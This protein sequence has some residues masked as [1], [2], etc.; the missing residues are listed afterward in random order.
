MGP[1][2]RSC[3]RQ[4]KAGSASDVNL[5]TIQCH[6][7]PSSSHPSSPSLRKVSHGCPQA[8][9]SSGLSVLGLLSP[10][11]SLSWGLSVLGPLC[12][13]ASQSWGLSV[14][15]PLCPGG[16]QSWGLSVL[17]PPCPG[18]LSVLGP[19]CPGGL[20]VLGPLC[21]GASLSWA[22]LSWGLSVCVYCL[23]GR[24][25]HHEVFN[26]CPLDPLMHLVVDSSRQILYSLSNSNTISVSHTHF[27]TPLGNMSPRPPQGVRPWERWVW[28]QQGG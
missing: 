9:L 22:S 25:S 24:S 10:G 17:G 4:G 6:T 12:P 16:S 15:R 18:G 1:S 20:S 13:V 3:T 26:L 28:S 5:S 2:T 8:S 14:L 7:F 27:P 21:P 23:V 11:T 19:L